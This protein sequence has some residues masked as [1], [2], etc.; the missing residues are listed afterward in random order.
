MKKLMVLVTLI[1]ASLTVKAQYNDDYDYQ[2]Y[3]DDR[4]YYD[5]E[6]DWHWDIRVR[7]SNGIDNGLITYNESQRLYAEL[8]R[9][10]RKEYAYQEDGYFTDW[11]QQDVWDDVVYLNR[12]VGVELYDR[13][14][15]FY[16]FDRVGVSR[17]G[18]SIW[19]YS[20]GYNFNRFDML[21]FGSIRYGYRP[22][23]NFT[24][25]SIY[26]HR[27]PVY[28]DRARDH[29]YAGSSR[30]RNNFS[31]SYGNNDRA[32]NN[33]GNPRGYERGGY[34]NSNR[35]SGRVESRGNRPGYEGNNSNRNSGNGSYGSRGSAPDRSDSPRINS[36]RTDGGSYGSRNSAPERIETPRSEGNGNSGGSYGSRDNAPQRME[37]PRSMPRN[38]GNARSESGRMSAPS[39]E[40]RSRGSVESGREAP[41]Q[42]SSAPA[43]RRGGGDDNRGRS[44]SRRQ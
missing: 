2:E 38:E 8:E 41:Q 11:E 18:F 21:G 25:R 10:E 1:V 32:R 13:D 26:V 3:N 30:G 35:N 36:N 37:T 16:G 28:R 44:N 42:R 29:F 23:P 43:E 40:G 27:H 22:R 17:R 19:F 15:V 24:R 4:Y 7:I 20:G 9:I 6:F 31:R 12:R 34:N 39:N 5:D 14:R 33:N